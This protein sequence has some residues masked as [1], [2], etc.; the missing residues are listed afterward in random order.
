MRSGVVVSAQL[1]G[2]TTVR[3]RETTSGLVVCVSSWTLN[4][5]S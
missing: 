2:V 4:T 1:F 3:M 5:R